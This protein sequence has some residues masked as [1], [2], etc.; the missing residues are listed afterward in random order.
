M[1]EWKKEVSSEVFMNALQNY[2]EATEII[3]N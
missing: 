1:R 3:L 2:D